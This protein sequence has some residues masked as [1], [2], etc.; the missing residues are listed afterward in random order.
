LK[1]WNPKIRQLRH[2]IADPA[3]FP[4][5]DIGSVQA[6]ASAERG[7]GDGP[8]RLRIADDGD[9]AICI[10]PPGSIAERFTATHLQAAAI[11]YGSAAKKSAN[12]AANMLTFPHSNRITAIYLASKACSRYSEVCCPRRT[13]LM[14]DVRGSHRIDAQA[15]PNSAIWQRYPLRNARQD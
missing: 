2:P 13:I 10:A 4:V 12:M 9:E 6:W 14:Y 8:V 3:V 11:P 5:D 7:W 15:T 1:D